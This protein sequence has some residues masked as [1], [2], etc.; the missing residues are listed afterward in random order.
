MLATMPLSVMA[1]IINISP[2]AQNVTLGEKFSVDISV[3]ELSA[4][5]VGGFDLRVEWNAMLLSFDS[6]IF[7][8]YFGDGST[9]SV[10]GSVIES[11]GIDVWEISL[12]NNLAFQND[13]TLFTLEFNTLASGEGDLTLLS[14]I[15]NNS[16][17][18]SDT[19]GSILQHDIGLAAGF[20]IVAVN[21]PAL[22]SL[23][24][25]GLLGIYGMRRGNKQ[26]S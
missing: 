26:R 5:I 2:A 24:G 20:K 11:G 13:L 21:E 19:S 3:N 23:F 18:L 14:A 7:S 9:N 16:F 25:L 1:T 15:P 17:G 6:L 10:R 22:L 8:G 4:E 12:L